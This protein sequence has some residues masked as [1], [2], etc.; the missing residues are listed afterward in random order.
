MF[1]GGFSDLQM[2]KLKQVLKSHYA[3]QN[4]TRDMVL[5]GLTT[6][7]ADIKKFFDTVLAVEELGATININIDQDY[8]L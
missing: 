2:G 3:R 8:I 5:Q 7:D 6:K 1:L 4:K